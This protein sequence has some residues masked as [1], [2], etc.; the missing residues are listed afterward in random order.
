M[1][2][3]SASIT[4][5]YEVMPIYRKGIIRMS[6]S[7]DFYMELVVEFAMEQSK[8]RKRSSLIFRVRD[9]VPA[10][11]ARDCKVSEKLLLHV[12]IFGA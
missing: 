7:V 9:R 6:I 3:S 8:R 12:P 11:S 4:E 1:Y 2:N 10:S 5:I